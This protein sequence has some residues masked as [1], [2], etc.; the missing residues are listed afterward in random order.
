MTGGAASFLV[1][2]AESELMWRR[3]T[4]VRP[5]MKPVSGVQVSGLKELPDSL[6][7]CFEVFV[8]GR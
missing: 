6:H 1:A 7:K 8:L 5:L 2:N 3:S 4:L